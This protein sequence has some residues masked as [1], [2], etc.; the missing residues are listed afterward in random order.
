VALTFTTGR[1]PDGSAV[2]VLGGSWRKHVG[3][4]SFRLN[5]SE[6]LTATNLDAW[7]DDLQNTYTT[8]V[9][10]LID[11]CFAG[12]FLDELAYTASLNALS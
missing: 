7:L 8:K 12:R 2:C 3:A 1:R 4:A 6:T 11:C 9:T 5:N 10:V